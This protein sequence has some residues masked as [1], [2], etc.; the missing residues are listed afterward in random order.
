MLAYCSDSLPLG[1]TLSVPYQQKNKRTELRIK[2][3]SELIDTVKQNE[4]VN[5]VVYQWCF[6]VAKRSGYSF[7][8]I[9][10]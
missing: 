1:H 3:A 7:K 2:N 9:I 4:H 10:G 8:T 5:L 6:H